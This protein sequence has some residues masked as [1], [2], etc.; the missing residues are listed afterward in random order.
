MIEMLV[1][2]DIPQILDCFGKVYVIDTEYYG[3]PGLPEGPVV[4]VALQAYE[5]RSGTWVSILFEKSDGPHTNPLDPD[6]L[7]LTFNASAEWNCF[8]SLGWALP[9]NCI[10]FYVEFKNQVSALKPPLQFRQ[11]RNPDKWNS[12]L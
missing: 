8:I 4:P 12:S 11:P 6:A 7:Y 3:T 10:D 1:A 9:R 2:A 5:V